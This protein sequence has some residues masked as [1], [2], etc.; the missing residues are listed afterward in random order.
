MKAGD[1]IKFEDSYPWYE[2][3]N[4]GDGEEVNFIEGHVNGKPVQLTA[5]TQL[6]GVF[7]DLPGMEPYDADTKAWKR[8]WLYTVNSHGD[9]SAIFVPEAKR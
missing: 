8:C 6:R 3:V 2:I 1:I 4:A 5:G 7:P 9:K